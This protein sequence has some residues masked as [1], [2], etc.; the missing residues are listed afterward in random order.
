MIQV[1]LL[2]EEQKDLLDGQLFDIDSYFGPIQD[3]NNNWVISI[4]EIDQTTN[5]EFF[6]V[7]SLTLIEY[8]PQP[9]PEL[10]TDL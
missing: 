6:W 7:K 8:I 2:T 5:E 4:E 9:D 10:P 1:G 3:N